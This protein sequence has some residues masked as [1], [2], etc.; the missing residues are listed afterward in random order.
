MSINRARGQHRWSS[1]LIFRPSFILIIVLSFQL[2]L[3]LMYMIGLIPS[4]R[5]QRKPVPIVGLA[6]LLLFDLLAVGMMLVCEKLKLPTINVSVRW[7]HFGRSLLPITSV[8][9]LMTIGMYG[10]LN[11]V[12]HMPEL[13]VGQYLLFGIQGK[14][15]AEIP[16][17]QS[18]TAA[19]VALQVAAILGMVVVQGRK[20]RLFIVMTSLGALAV[21]S[22]IYMSRI[23][24]IPPLIALLVLYM[25]KKSGS[26]STKKRNTIFIIMLIIVA[27]IYLAQGLRDY[28]I[29]GK[30]YTKSLLAWGVSRLLDY[31]I[32]TALYSAY[33]GSMVEHAEMSDPRFYFGA[34]EYTNIGSLGQLWRSFGITYL[35]VLLGFCFLVGKYW[36][37]FYKGYTDGLIV[38][39]FMVYSLLELPRMF[40]FTTVT[41]LVRLALLVVCG[42]LFRNVPAR[43][44]FVSKNT[45]FGR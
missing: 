43:G 39:P 24:L 2:F 13:T 7:G 19:H 10:L 9:V 6:H 26:I 29:M 17:G 15:R 12:R 18:F 28:D 20:L 8:G 27:Y 5:L 21:Y 31:Y 30:L 37:R 23:M 44:D 40:E 16:W 33:I 3:S 42:W 22:V 32:S 14:L 11:V 4:L 34:P 25:Q 35:F 38:F 36:R 45:S 41:G 1:R